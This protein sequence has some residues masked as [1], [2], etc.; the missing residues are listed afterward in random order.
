[1]A[2]QHAIAPVHG[3][4]MTARYGAAMEEREE[5]DLNR[6]RDAMRQHDE[7]EQLP[8]EAEQEPSEDEPED[9]DS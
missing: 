1:M 9:D 5:P 3:T 6:V 2:T 4:E 7:R 8:E